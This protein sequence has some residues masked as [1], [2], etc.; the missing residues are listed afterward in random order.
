MRKPIWGAVALM[1][2]VSAGLGLLA[3]RLLIKP[4]GHSDQASGVSAVPVWMVE[5]MRERLDASLRSHVMPE[6]V[7][8]MTLPP[9]EQDQPASS[10]ADLAGSVTLDGGKGL[11]VLY[12]SGEGGYRAAYSKEEPLFSLQHAG[13]GYLV[14]STV[15]PASGGQERT[16]YI[17][18]KT[19]SGYREVW[20]GMAHRHKKGE[21]T[22]LLDGTVQIDPMR[23]TMIYF[24][25]ERTLDQTGL[26]LMEKSS[27]ELLRYN[28]RTHRFEK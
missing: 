24:R 15:K 27:Y 4:A 1:M 14:V 8:V 7:H 2:L 13:G 25:L 22:E 11:F 9:D 12:A 18:R 26:S 28:E 20:S 6:R 10:P 19:A 5:D 3:G 21:T 16:L 17:L 23:H